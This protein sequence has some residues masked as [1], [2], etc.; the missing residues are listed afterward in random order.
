VRVIL[1]GASAYFAVDLDDS[2]TWTVTDHSCQV[3]A[4][5][6]PPSTSGR[7]GVWRTVL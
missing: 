6:W 3:E 1:V 5:F 7:A 4:Q 2:S